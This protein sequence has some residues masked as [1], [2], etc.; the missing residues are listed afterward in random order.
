MPTLTIRDFPETAH[1]AL[2]ILAARRGGRRSVEGFAR[3]VLVEV[4]TRQSS[5]TPGFGDQ[6]VAI[7][8]QLHSDLAAAGERLSNEDV[9]A[10]FKRL[11]E[12]VE[13]ASFE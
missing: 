2:K 11:D 9:D 7:G 12:S 6:L 5:S 4:A 3:T 1:A 8:R 13:P 10:L